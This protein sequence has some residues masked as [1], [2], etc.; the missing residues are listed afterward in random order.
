MAA[1]MS[2]QEMVEA[3]CDSVAPKFMSRA[4]IKSFL[5]KNNGFV[6]TPTNKAHL[7]KALTKLD[8]KGDSF[9]KRKSTKNTEAAKAKKA[10]R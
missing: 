9:R 3:A 8:K 5:T 7:K 6:E 4:A 1:K 2:W 10:L